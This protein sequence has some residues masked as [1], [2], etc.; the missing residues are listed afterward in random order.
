MRRREFIAA[1]GGA[2]ALPLAAR[3]QQTDRIRHIGALVGLREDDPE[4]REWIAA[5]EQTL[6]RL[7]WS[8]GRNVRIDYRYSPA[9]FRVQELAGE[10]VAAQPDVILAYSTPSS[11]ALKQTSSTIPIVFLGVTDPIGSGLITSLARPGGN[12]TGLIMYDEKV[13]TKWLLMLKEIAPNLK[14]VALVINPKSA[15]Y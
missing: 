1:L 10:V 8:A 3:A 13:A 15:P 6:G 7:G 14:R 11:I 12:L 4:V 5:F 2:A 9:A